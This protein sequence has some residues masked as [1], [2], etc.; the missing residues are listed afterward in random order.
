MGN[1]KKKLR[2]LGHLEAHPLAPLK[3]ALTAVKV[4]NS[5]AA[6]MYKL[7]GQSLNKRTGQGFKYIKY[8]KNL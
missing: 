1:T 3:M 6:T 5:E 7:K 2:P 8:L 4:S